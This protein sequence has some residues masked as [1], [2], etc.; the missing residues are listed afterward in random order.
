[1]VSEN[2]MVDLP[3]D[4]KQQGERKETEKKEK[5]KKRKKKKK[6]TNCR[7]GT[8]GGGDRTVNRVLFLC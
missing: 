1:M 4:G 6:K 8:Q 3:L 2:K 7:R 5:K